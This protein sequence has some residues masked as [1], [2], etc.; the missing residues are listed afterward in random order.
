MPSQDCRD[1]GV[2]DF[3]MVFFRVSIFRVRLPC[4]WVTSFKSPSV[5]SFEPT[6]S[7]LPFLFRQ[8]FSKPRWFIFFKISSSSASASSSTDLELWGILIFVIYLAENVISPDLQLE[9]FCPASDTFPEILILATS[10]DVF[11]RQSCL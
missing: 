7:L 5:L 10:M 3:R 8:I 6:E 9:S 2:I 4:L 1:S 11:P